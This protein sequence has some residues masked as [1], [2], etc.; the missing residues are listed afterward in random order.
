MEQAD[1]IGAAT[2]AGDEE[3]GQPALGIEDLL[4]RFE[5]DDALEVAN[6]A[7]IG[8]GPERRAEQVMGGLDVRDPVADCFVDG[9]LEG[10]AAAINAADIRSE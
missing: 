10:T 4:A 2:D 7:G 3:V 5:A 8:V 6:D 1:S 9:V